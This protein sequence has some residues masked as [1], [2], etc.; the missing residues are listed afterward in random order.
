MS[1]GCGCDGT[2]E[3]AVATTAFA[4]VSSMTDAPGLNGGLTLPLNTAGADLIVVHVAYDARYATPEL[5]DSQTNDWIQLS[6]LA[7]SITGH[8]TWYAK[9]ARGHSA[10]TFRVTGATPGVVV[11]AFRGSDLDNPLQ[12]STGA[13]TPQGTSLKPGA[14]MPDVHGSLVLTWFS[15]WYPCGPPFTTQDCVTGLSDGLTLTAK[16]TTHDINVA[17]ATGYTIQGT[18]APVDPVYYWPSA[19]EAQAGIAVFR[20]AAVDTS[21]TIRP[22]N[23]ATARDFITQTLRS[24]RVLGVGDPLSA[25]DANDALARLNDWLD[26]LALERLTMYFVTR[27]CKLLGNNICSYTIGLGGDIGI[28]RPTH[29]ESANLIQNVHDAVPFEKPI[30]VWTDQRWQGCR[31]KSLTSAYPSAIYYDHN[32]QAGLGKIHVWPVPTDC[33]QMQ[34]VLYTPVAL[35]E[36]AS[37][38]ATYTFPPGYRR[39]IRTNFAAEI[40]SEY[41]KQLTA[42]QVAAAKQAKAQIKRGNVRPVEAR[43]DP[44]LIRGYDYFDWRTG[45]PR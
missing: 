14:V 32:W 10:H 2:G 16:P 38:D 9:R 21:A 15:A 44:A 22:P 39:F 8:R 26:A 11:H 43:V 17:A 5:T 40:A 31:Q 23:T 1:C 4:P 34:L 18:A 41:G 13:M 33:G 20:P 12:E 24:I 28:V 36:F 29:I 37:L 35:L 6:Q 45:E 7:G 30:D 42:D 25:D 19:Q 3:H 27:T